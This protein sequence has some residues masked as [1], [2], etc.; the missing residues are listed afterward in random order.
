MAKKISS[1]SISQDIKKLAS[2]GLVKID[3]RKLTKKNI[4]D[5]SFRKK[6]LTTLRKF[7]DETKFLSSL[8]QNGKLAKVK[9]IADVEALESRGHRTHKSGL[10]FIESKPNEKVRV[11]QRGNITYERDFFSTKK[12]KTIKETIYEPN[13]NL[14]NVQSVEDA[15]NL[16]AEMFVNSK[17]KIAFTY[18]GHISRRTYADVK[19]AMLQVIQYVQSQNDIGTSLNPADIPEIMKAIQIFTYDDNDFGHDR[20]AVASKKSEMTKYFRKLGKKKGK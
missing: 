10:V 8:P 19:E 7:K 15:V 13:I 9:N 14:S 6:L 2:A 4:E 12:R 5:K 1:E 11:T 16:Y 3:R 18:Y 17:K 20:T